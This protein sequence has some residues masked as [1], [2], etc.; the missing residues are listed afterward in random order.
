MSEV[1]VLTAF[2]SLLKGI[3]QSQHEA[4]VK[5]TPLREGGVSYLRDAVQSVSESHAQS[6]HISSAIV[7]LRSA[8]QGLCEEA[9]EPAKR[10]IDIVCQCGYA[11][12]PE[13]ATTIFIDELNSN[14]STVIQRFTESHCKASY[15][16]FA[17]HTKCEGD[18]VRARGAH[19]PRNTARPVGIARP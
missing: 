14:I 18:A 11:H 13:G 12:Y 6:T 1:Q 4:G 16:N 5:M 3:A 7:D 8:R 15:L 19:H 10:L 17:Q 2:L 9:H